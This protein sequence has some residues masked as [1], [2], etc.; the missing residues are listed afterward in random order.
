MRPLKFFSRFFRNQS[1]ASLTEKKVI[2]LEE[3]FG[4]G[5]TLDKKP[6]AQQQLA[7][8]KVA[9]R[10]LV[11]RLEHIRAEWC[12]TYERI[13][14]FPPLST[15]KVPIEDFVSKRR[16]TFLRV[17]KAFAGSADLLV[18]Y[19][20]GP[21]WINARFAIFAHLGGL[22]VAIFTVF[23]FMGVWGLGGKDHSNPTPS[24]RRRERWL[25][26][27]AIFA[28]LL[29]LSLTVERFLNLPASLLKLLLGF[30]C[31]A[32][33]MLAAGAH[34]L[35]DE[36][37]D[38]NRQVR[39]YRTVQGEYRRLQVLTIKMEAVLEPQELE[40]SLKFER[41]LQKVEAEE[42]LRDA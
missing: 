16:T 9:V 26:V 42:V 36:V 4:G 7:Y 30:S 33:S 23:L 21:A 19:I 17:L 6:V 41:E 1:D 5:A 8:V 28:C 37:D 38:L 27:V 13:K 32:L 22:L 20:A 39:E 10:E 12:L 34:V 29:V 24:L 40:Q 25:W 35:A 18:G 3:R 15:L 31:A 11:V 2:E 14:G